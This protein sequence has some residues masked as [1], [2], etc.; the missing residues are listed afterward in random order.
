M[1]IHPGSRRLLS[2][3]AANVSSWSDSDSGSASGSFGYDCASCDSETGTLIS[4]GALL[5]LF[6]ALV[7]HRPPGA[8]LPPPP[9]PAAWPETALRGFRCSSQATSR[10][11]RVPTARAFSAASTC[12]AATSTVPPLP[13]CVHLPPLPLPPPP[14]PPTLPPPHCS[15]CAPA[16]SVP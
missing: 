11:L 9:V 8:P 16:V 5:A 14:P 1:L 4:V 3:A 15:A 6:C 12:A 2:D 13:G 10:S 7:R